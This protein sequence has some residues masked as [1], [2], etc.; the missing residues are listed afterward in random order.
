[1]EV[2]IESSNSSCTEES[3]N[4]PFTYERHLKYRNASGEYNSRC[5]NN[6]EKGNNFFEIISHYEY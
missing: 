3:C 1:M 5:S 2:R 6:N 4:Y